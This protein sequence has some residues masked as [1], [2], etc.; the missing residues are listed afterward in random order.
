MPTA[1]PRLM[2]TL[3]PQMYAVVKR[4]AQLQGKPMSRALL[5]LLDGLE[6]VLQSVVATLEAA[7]VAE[8]EP[9][10]KLLAS[11]MKLH[12]ELEGV[13]SHALNQFDFFTAA[14]TGRA[15]EQE[16][17]EQSDPTPAGR[18]QPAKRALRRAVKPRRKRTRG[19][20]K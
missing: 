20:A 1:K 3:R 17:G 14:A 13:A 6:P 11:A 12:Q 5:D 8:G 15:A 10:A 19:R 16:G 4:L 7:R 18:Q 9:R 2:L